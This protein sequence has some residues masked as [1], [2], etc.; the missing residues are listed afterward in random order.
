MNSPIHELCRNNED[1]EVLAAMAVTKDFKALLD[2]TVDPRFMREEQRKIAQVIIDR[3]STDVDW[4]PSFDAL[5]AE[6]GAR[7]CFPVGWT[8]K[9]MQGLNLNHY[10]T[11]FN[12]QA[13]AWAMQDVAIKLFRSVHTLIGEH[14]SAQE[15]AIREFAREARNISDIGKPRQ[16]AYVVGQNLEDIRAEI[17]GKRTRTSLC[18]THIPMQ[19]ALIRAYEP[20]VYLWFSRMKNGKTHE[21][22]QIV[23]ENAVEAGL[24]GVYVDRENNRKDI[25]TR[26]ACAIVGA[27]YHHFKS[28]ALKVHHYDRT[29]QRGKYPLADFDKHLFELVMDSFE[30]LAA[31]GALAIIDKTANQQN[32][33][34]P[35][36][37]S[38]FFTINEVLR[39]ADKHD[40]QWVAFDQIQRYEIDNLRKGAAANERMEKTFAL[41]DSYDDRI[42]FG[43]CQENRE[44]VDE[45][46]QM[47]FPKTAHIYGGDT[48]AQMCS[49]LCHVRTVRMIHPVLYKD[50][51]GIERQAKFMRCF[52]PLLNRPGED[53]GTHARWFGHLDHYS[54]SEYLPGDI[55][56]PMF[57]GVIG[58]AREAAGLPRDWKEKPGKKSAKAGKSMGKMPSSFTSFSSDDDE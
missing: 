34:D 3:Y 11:R 19:N 21:L 29:H 39:A 33:R 17:T 25:L 13:R 31:T 22:N 28:L 42:F 26:M 44:G 23:I 6:F 20:G 1:A 9:D 8:K 49:Y 53:A 7:A 41:L 45:D 57:E 37:T 36:R 5:L 12:A 40:A 58:D 51:Y 48:A 2:G 15:E 14:D 30:E 47:H 32:L 16:G 56:F 10:I 24:R 18:R 38:S 50:I 46:T 35:S 55:G 43:T 54:Y 52:T 27:P 4:P